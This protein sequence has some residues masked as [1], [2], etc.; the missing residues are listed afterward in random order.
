MTFLE[1]IPIYVFLIFFGLVILGVR[2]LKDRQ[3]TLGRVLIFPIVMNLFSIYAT[4]GF[5][6]DYLVLVGWVVGYL[7]IV[8]VNRNT[9][10]SLIRIKWGQ[11]LIKRGSFIPLV[12]MLLIFAL[13][14]VMGFIKVRYPYLMDMLVVFMPVAL[15]GGILS[16]SLLI[17]TFSQLKRAN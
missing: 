3:V 7:S 6:S 1:H 2:Q 17:L 4:W 8:F 9:I 10:H 13:R 5:H 15:L 16:A 12:L 11:S 14:F